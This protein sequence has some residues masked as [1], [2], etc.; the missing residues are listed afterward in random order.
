[1]PV[2]V[3]MNGALAGKTVTA[4]L[5]RTNGS[6]ALTSDGQIFSWGQAALGGLGNGT[7]TDSIV[8]T[9]V[10]TSGILNGK[11]VTKL[12]SAH[13]TVLAQ[14]SDGLLVGFGENISGI[15]GTGNF[16][17][18]LLPVQVQAPSGVTISQLGVSGWSGHALFL[19]STGEVY[20]AGASWAMETPL[21]TRPP[22][23]CPTPPSAAKR[24]WLSAAG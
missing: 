6:C 16:V 22:Y 4:V 19:T 14:T 8:P 9:A 3:V 23:S 1:V 12:G 2:A 17:N 15:L 5:A 11:M 18:S 20:A 10:T 24:S 21:S 7:N 13:N